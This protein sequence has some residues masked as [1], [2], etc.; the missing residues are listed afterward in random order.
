MHSTDTLSRAFAMVNLHHCQLCNLT[1]GLSRLQGGNGEKYL[2]NH[3]L[4]G[5][6]QHG[7]VEVL[8]HAQFVGMQRELTE[9]LSAHF[10]LTENE[11]VSAGGHE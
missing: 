1:Y 5:D 11:R 7:I 6:D 8:K 9:N 2:P 10:V 3:G 4:N